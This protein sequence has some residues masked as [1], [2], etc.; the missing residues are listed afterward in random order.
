MGLV[1]IESFGGESLDRATKL[2][3]GISGGVE[4]AVQSAMPRAASHLRTQSSE[5][6][7]ERYAIS[8]SAIRSNENVKIH[9]SYQSGSGVCATITFS[10]R[11]IPLY[12]FDGAAPKQPTQDPGKTIRAIIAGQWRMAHPGVSASGHQLRS[13][14]ATRFQDA[15]VAKMAS[16]HIG[17]FERSGAATPAGS[18]AIKEIM[19]SSV[20]QMVGNSEVAESLANDASKKF[21]ERMEREILRIMNGWGG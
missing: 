18:D 8:H 10:G 21:E 20:S 7:R 4:K 1:K 12:R 19:G 17:I 9:Y 6:I 16:G 5:R 15:F 2:L 11:K 14:G 13:T 3:A